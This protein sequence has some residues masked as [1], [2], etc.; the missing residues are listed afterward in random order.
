MPLTDLINLLDRWSPER[1]VVAGDFM[2]DRTTY[3]DAARLAPDAPVPVL[4]AQRSE[5][6]PGGAGNVCV[7]LAALGCRAAALGVVGDDEAGRKLRDAL[8]AAGVDTAGL[9]AGPRPTTVKHS[10]VGLA[11]GRHA[12]KMFRFDTEDARPIPSAAEARLLEHAQELLEGA[13]VL[14][15]EDYGKGVLT[16]ALCRGLIGLAKRRG[17]PVLVDPPALGGYTK[18]RGATCL[19]PNRTEA[20]RATGLDE[21]EAMA[22][23][24]KADLDLSLVVLTLDKSGALLLDEH[25]RLHEVPTVPRRVYDVTGA[26]DTVLATLAAAATQ[27]AAWPDAVELANA[28]AGLAV[29]K[30]GARPVGFDELWLSVL[31]RHRRELGKP[32]TLTALCRELEAHRKL[33]KSVVFTNGCFDVLHAGH[34]TMLRHAAQLGDLLVVGLNADASIARLKGANRPVNPEADRR[35]VL[36]ELE[37]VDYVVGFERDTPIELIEAIRPD[38]LVKGADYRIDEVVGREAV[39]AYGGRVE[40]IELVQGKSTSALLEQTG[41]P[42]HTA[43]E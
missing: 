6:L 40:L 32:R 37:S 26:G 5:E 13:A 4:S 22:R 16:E 7:G 29:E 8:D 20:R 30:P 12:Q 3:G 19:T 21:P 41:G 14:C 38:V 10:L 27:G 9:A 39:E 25:G 17:I 23:R 31:G 42:S 43:N 33:G 24:L 15:L 2:L 35:L 18:Y 1:V 36:S 11:Q 28:A 34:V